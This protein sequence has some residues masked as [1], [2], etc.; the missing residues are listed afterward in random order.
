MGA[1][2]SS[3]S[4]SPGDVSLVHLLVFLC[5]DLRL[6]VFSA[7]VLVTHRLAQNKAAAGLT[8]GAIAPPS[9]FSD[10]LLRVACVVFF[11]FVQISMFMIGDVN[12]AM[13]W[14]QVR[15][16]VRVTGHPQALLTRA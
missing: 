16:R 1:S 7:D 3:L 8:K 9:P 5:A 11:F 15:V 6:D 13:H 4:C 2:S 12:D 14:I 10:S